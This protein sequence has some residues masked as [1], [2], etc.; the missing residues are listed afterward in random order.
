MILYDEVLC[1]FV[2]GYEKMQKIKQVPTS[3][4]TTCST[5]KTLTLFLF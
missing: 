3:K 4:T 1:A 5:V 2:V